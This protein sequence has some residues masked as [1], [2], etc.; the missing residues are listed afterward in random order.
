MMFSTRFFALSCFLIL[1][2]FLKSQTLYFK[3]TTVSTPSI[4]PW[5]VA[6]NWYT[7]AA[8]T[9]STTT[10]IPVSTNDVIIN[11]NAFTA[12]NQK[13]DFDQSSMACKGFSVTYNGT[14][15]NVAMQSVAGNVLSVFGHFDLT[16]FDN[17]KLSIIN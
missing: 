17:S 9:M 14:Y 1:S 12:N 13:I 6:S 11:S 16:S 3:C 2:I 5:S 4:Y 8:C 15:T 10:G 7:D